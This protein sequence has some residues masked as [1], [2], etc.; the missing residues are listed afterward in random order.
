VDLAAAWP[1]ERTTL[2]S[3]NP[4]NAVSDALVAH[5]FAV[6]GALALAA[7]AAWAI[8]SMRTIAIGR[9]PQVRARSDVA[10]AGPDRLDVGLLG[11]GGE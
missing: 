11:A 9:P 4:L 6:A 3:A 1:A 2:I 5:P 8:P 10:E 7:A